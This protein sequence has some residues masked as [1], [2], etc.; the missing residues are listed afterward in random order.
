SENNGEELNFDISREMSKGETDADD[1]CGNKELRS[2]HEEECRHL[3]EECMHLEEQLRL[4]NDTRMTR[5]MV[6]LIIKELSPAPDEDMNGM[7]DVYRANAIRNLCRI[8]DGTLLIQIERYTR[9]SLATEVGRSITLAG[10]SKVLAFAVGSFIYM[11]A[12]QDYR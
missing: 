6:N 2:Q 12:C 3:K 5:R 7:S 11:P 1:G 8:I 10:L 9:N 4:K